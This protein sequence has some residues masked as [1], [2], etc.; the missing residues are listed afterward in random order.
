MLGVSWELVGRRTRKPQHATQYIC[1]E[2]IMLLIPRALHC[3]VHHRGQWPA[4]NNNKYCL[5]PPSS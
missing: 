3:V 5:R 2:C 1:H 4:P